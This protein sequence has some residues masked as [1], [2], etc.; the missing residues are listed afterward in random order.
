MTDTELPESLATHRDG[1]E[2]FLARS[3]GAEG[4]RLVAARAL[5]GGAIQENWLLEIDF[6][7][8][9]EAGR[10]DLVLRT[11]APSGVASSR[12]RAEEFILLGTAQT[13]GVPVPE[14]LWLCSDSEV[15]GRPFYVMRR[16]PGE[17][18]GYKLVKAGAIADGNALAVELGTAL[19]RIHTIAPPRDDLAFLGAPP[20]NPALA[21]VATYRDYLDALPDPHPELEWGL[22]WCERHAPEGEITLVHQDFRTGNYMVHEGGLSGVLDWEFCAWGD[23][24]SDIGWFT[25]KCWRFGRDELEAGG[26]AG[27]QPFYEAYEETAG[28]RIDAEAVAYWEVMAHLR[29]AVI[30]LQQGERCNSGAEETL[31]LA[32]IGRLYP[33]EL[34]A[35]VLRLTAPDSWKAAS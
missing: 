31:D 12:S 22:R 23:P 6:I 16:I 4:A 3:S 27:R 9:S 11:D 33:V 18:T 20:E 10:Q 34:A 26:I 1:L 13:A 15:L 25:A 24:M 21:A 2:A 5:T 32:L 8:G 14:P 17:A 28:R 35:E 29:W 30:A 7:G 19:A